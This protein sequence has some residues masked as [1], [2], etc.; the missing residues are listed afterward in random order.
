MNRSD[1]RFHFS[2]AALLIAVIVMA[3]GGCSKEEVQES[4]Y[5]TEPVQAL[6]I[7]REDILSMQTLRMPMMDTDTAWYQVAWDDVLYEEFVA[8]L[9]HGGPNEKSWADMYV[10]ASNRPEAATVLIE[11]CREEFDRIDFGNHDFNLLIISI[12]RS[13]NNLAKRVED[14]EM[15]AALGDFVIECYQ[16]EIDPYDRGAKVV[17]RSLAELAVAVDEK[18]AIPYI[19]SFIEEYEWSDGDIRTLRGYLEELK[20]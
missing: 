18:R 5:E 7:I 10:A 19:E 9:R 3:F 2:G 12:I 15:H 8:V 6:E 20:G 1:A 16:R 11:V 17:F 13:M 4:R 14:E